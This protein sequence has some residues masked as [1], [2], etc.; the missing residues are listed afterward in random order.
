MVDVKPFSASCHLMLI[1]NMKTQ[2]TTTYLC[3]NPLV[4][5]D[6]RTLLSTRCQEIIAVKTKNVRPRVRLIHFICVV[7]SEKFGSRQFWDACHRAIKSN[8]SS[9]TVLCTRFACGV[10]GVSKT[11][12]SLNSPRTGS[13]LT[14]LT[15]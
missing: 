10:R 12:I 7:S 13:S 8:N 2:D 1:E 14:L 5:A 4:E 11:K 3:C 9:T 15:I 6:L